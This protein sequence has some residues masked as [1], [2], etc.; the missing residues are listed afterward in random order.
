M[1]LGYVFSVL[2]IAATA[3]CALW[4]R[5]TRGPHA[6]PTFV[7][8][9]IASEIPFM[10]MWYLLLITWA[11]FDNGE[12]ASALGIVAAVVAA[13]VLLALVRIIAQSLHA[14]PTLESALNSELG[15]D[16]PRASRAGHWRRSL[17]SLVAPL[18]IPNPWVRR[19]RNVSYGPG[20]KANLLDV[21][22]RRGVASGPVFIY[23]HPGGFHSGSKNRQAK[24]LLET[25][26][27]HGWVC[28]S[29][30]Y[31]LRVPFLV[32]LADV[33]RVIAWVRNEGTRY[34]ADG[35]IPV[36]GGGSAGAQL[37]SHCGVSANHPE[38][39]PG[40][41]DADTGVAAV[42]GLYGYYGSAFGQEFSDPAEF[43][44]R[45][46]PPLLVI[47][48]AEDPMAPLTGAEKFAVA[49]RTRHEGAIVYAELPGAVH[50]F[51]LFASLRHAAVV[52]A[53]LEFLAW[54]RG[55]ETKVSPA[56]HE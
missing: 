16:R 7:L 48:G 27:S 20:G 43:T 24:L 47:H 56:N 30:N 26:A 14:L 51:D 29:A 35:G 17:W 41:E 8:G 38:L 25:L 39:Q 44:D 11:A 12:L 21:Y 49:M 42:V 52:M 31:H 37:A 34:G 33:K 28:V 32:A 6:T 50:N 10:L 3:A 23:L 55:T 15:E 46:V 5:P 54:V 22:R 9:T 4:P 19:Y 36:I 13:V 40:L 53:V 1:P 45:P 2:L 18:R